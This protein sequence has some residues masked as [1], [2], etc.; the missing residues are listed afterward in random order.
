MSGRTIFKLV[1]SEEKASSQLCIV[2]PIGSGEY[3]CKPKSIHERFDIV[4]FVV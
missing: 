2:L 4:K 3:A 1:A